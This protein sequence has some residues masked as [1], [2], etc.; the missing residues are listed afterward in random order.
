LLGIF[1]L[2]SFKLCNLRFK[3]WDGLS[4][5]LETFNFP[6]LPLNLRLKVFEF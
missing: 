4:L 5:I 6:T 2:L 1:F 3:L